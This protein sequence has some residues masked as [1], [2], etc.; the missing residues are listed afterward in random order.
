M[1]KTTIIHPG[2]L[3]DCPF[4]GKPP[5]LE[6][7][8]IWEDQVEVY[9]IFCNECRFGL[10]NETDIDEVIKIWNKRTPPRR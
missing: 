2:D 7:A 1:R 8:R 4:C 5:T 6:T 9:D 3:L 10:V